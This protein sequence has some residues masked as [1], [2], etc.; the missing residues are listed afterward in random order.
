MRISEMTTDQFYD[1]LVDVSPYVWEFMEDEKIASFFAERKQKLKN[2][3]AAGKVG[4][5]LIFDIIVIALKERRQDTHGILAALS[6]TSIDTIKDQFPGKTIGQ[7]F[8][9]VMDLVS[10]NGLLNDVVVF[11][12][13]AE[14]S[15]TEK[16]SDI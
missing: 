10:N 13:Q 3:I 1:V 4:K 9:L 6:G 2:G 5:R 8:E 15:A 11:F 7:L 14:E 16:P 12:D